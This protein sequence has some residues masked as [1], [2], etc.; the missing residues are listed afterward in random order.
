M[1]LQISILFNTC[2]LQKINEY[3]IKPIK[4]DLSAGKFSININ[5]YK[6]LQIVCFSGWHI[7][8]LNSSTDY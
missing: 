7:S 4:R 8:S 3:D 2:I 5:N 6:I 1:S